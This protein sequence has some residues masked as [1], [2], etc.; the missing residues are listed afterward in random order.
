MCGIT[1]ILNINNSKNIDHSDNLEIKRM[2]KLLDHRGSD[3]TGYFYNDDI[4]FGHK[5]LKIIDLKNGQQ[6]M[7]LRKNNYILSG[8]NFKKS[9]NKKIKH[10]F[11]SISPKNLSIA[12]ISSMVYL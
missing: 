8:S 4:S 9:R 10:Q 5:R 6:P 3:E 2:T 11:L 12:S 1:G 7:T